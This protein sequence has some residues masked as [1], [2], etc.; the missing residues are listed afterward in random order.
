MRWLVV[1]GMFLALAG[2]RDADRGI[3]TAELPRLVLQT[4]D[5]RATFTRFDFGRQVRLDLPSGQRADAGR[6]GRLAG[7][8]ARYRRAGS[9]ATSGPLVVESRADAFKDD[10]GA[11][12]ELEAI[13]EEWAAAGSSEKLD[14]GPGDAALSRSVSQGSGRY[15][16]RFFEV[17]WRSRN[18]VGFV[19]ASGFAGRITL[20]DALS[21]ARKQ[22]QRISR[23]G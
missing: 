20:A 5:V 6:F 11:T 7:W 12:D 23:P 14:A 22:Q 17:A 8:K 16:T 3:S 4:K 15:A 21:L 2:C 1:A 10:G 19:S 13:A 9:R 18:V